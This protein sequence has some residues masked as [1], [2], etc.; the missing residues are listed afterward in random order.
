MAARE[1][2]DAGSGERRAVGRER[3]A[4]QVAAKGRR[5]GRAVGGGMLYESDEEWASGK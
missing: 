4:M 3:R 5:A 1:A 2:S